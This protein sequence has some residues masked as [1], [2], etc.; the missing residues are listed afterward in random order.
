MFKHNDRL[1]VK[2]ISLTYEQEIHKL[3]YD[4]S[5]SSLLYNE[6]SKRSL[7]FSH[8]RNEDLKSLEGVLV[9]KSL[10]LQSQRI[11]LWTCR[12]LSKRIFETNC[13]LF[14]IPLNK[15][16]YSQFLSLHFNKE[17]MVGS[18][19]QT[20]PAGPSQSC[21]QDSL[22]KKKYGGSENNKIFAFKNSNF[23][24]RW[25]KIMLGDCYLEKLKKK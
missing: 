8:Q 16:N 3:F 24:Y 12:P 13:F 10:A 23:Y 5:K 6:A 19:N 21:T 20:A 4:K 14:H 2:S 17:D 18:L 7:A 9:F 15:G 1:P 11:S 22:A 25:C